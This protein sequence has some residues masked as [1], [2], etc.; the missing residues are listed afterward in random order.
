[1]LI[2]IIEQFGYKD[3]RWKVNL[4]VLQ[5][6][7]TVSFHRIPLSAEPRIHR[8]EPRKPAFLLQSLEREG[9]T[10]VIEAQDSNYR[11]DGIPVY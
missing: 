9:L 4:I 2:C 8:P 3:E 5:C 1:M 6:V 7:F 11:S 10:N